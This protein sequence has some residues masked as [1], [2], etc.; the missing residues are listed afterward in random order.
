VPEHWSLLVKTRDDLFSVD[1]GTDDAAAQAA[2]RE[3]KGLMN[4]T[5][6]VT[7]AGSLVVM[8]SEIESIALQ[9]SAAARG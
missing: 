2:L 5:G 4:E 9:S 1:V 3:A 8:A 6:T 7:I